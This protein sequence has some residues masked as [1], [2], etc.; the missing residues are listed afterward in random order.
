[1][2][3]AKLHDKNYIVDEQTKRITFLDARFYATKDGR[4]FPSVTT[5]L[6]AYP[7]GFGYY[8]WLKKV[9]DDADEIRDE[10]GRK[11]SIVHKMT[12]EYDLGH[13]INLLNE[14]GDP[15]CRMSEWSMF[16]RYVEFRR[17]FEPT[18]HEIELNLCSPDLGYGG[19]LDRV[20]ALNGKRILVDIKTGNSVYNHFWLQQ[21]AYRKLL[22]DCKPKLAKID[23]VGILHLN[24]KTRTN[25][26]K[27]AIQGMGWQLILR[28]DDAEKD[29]EVFQATKRLWEAENNDIKPKCYSYSL[30]HFHER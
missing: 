27:D 4:Y 21:S 6:E 25:G 22:A 11:G 23:D 20:L 7:K 19:T 14:A 16:E 13:E 2:A 12:E 24:A 5:L 10:A 3:I 8:E 17:R 18:I 26:T 30:K 9:G 29:W 15:I 1:M 28:G